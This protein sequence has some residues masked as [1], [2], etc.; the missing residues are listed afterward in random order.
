MKK[1]LI[2]LAVLATAGTASAQSVSIFGILDAAITHGRAD[3]T[4]SGNMTQMTSGSHTIS[5]IGFRGREDLGSGLAASFWLEAQLFLD[6]G[7]SGNTLTS[8]N[9]TPS[10]ANGLN[11]SRR[12]TVSLEGSWGE[13][14][15]GRDVVP[16]SLNL[17]VFDPFGNA[18]VGATILVIGPPTAL[19]ASAATFGLV[20]AG[21]GAAGPFARAS[22]M[23]SYFSPPNLGGAYL[24][25]SYW[26]GEN[27]Q[28]GA[29]NED[30]GTGGSLRVGYARGAFNGAVGWGRTR[31]RATPVAAS[32]GAP[33]GDFTSWNIGAQWTFGVARLMGLYGREKRESA[34]EAEGRGW[35]VGASM[36]VGVGEIRASFSQYEIDGGPGADPRA[37]KLAIGYVHNLSKR[38]AVYATAAR[39]RN[40][41]GARVALAGSTFG[42]GVTNGSATGF[43]FGIRHAF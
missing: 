11:F 10:P 28:N 17:A 23:V 8:S 7:R 30:D 31:Y 43:D 4:G 27:P 35:L 2:S 21:Q 29:T 42:A 32:P 37:R 34:V 1:T 5:R 9:Q 26:L 20:P 19:G 13:L 33:S 25:G 22:N 15:F 6:D 18:G 41:D 24:Q 14:R 38:T 12:A 3:G 36:P 16:S 39:V 40:S